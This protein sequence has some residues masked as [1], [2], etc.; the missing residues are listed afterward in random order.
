MSAQ[1][2]EKDIVPMD[3]GDLNWGSIK[4][5]LTA[6]MTHPPTDDEV[7]MFLAICQQSGLNPFTQEVYGIKYSAKDK[8]QIITSKDAFVK[9]ARAHPQFKG[10]EAGIIVIREGKV[11][12]LVGSFMLGNDKLVGGWA[13]AHLKDMSVPFE[14]KVALDEYDKGRGTWN[15][16]QKTM[17]RKVA[18]VHV[19]RE[20]F[21]EVFSKV[22]DES[23][24]D[25]AHPNRD[26]IKD[27]QKKQE[28]GEATIVETESVT[29]E[30]PAPLNP[31]LPETEVTIPETEV[32]ETATELPQTVEKE[33]E[34]FPDDE[35]ASNGDEIAGGKILMAEGGLTLNFGKHRG[36]LLYNV[37]RNTEDKEYLKWILEQDFDDDLKKIIR[38]E[39]NMAEAESA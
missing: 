8:M 14:D 19:L 34:I 3:Q 24:M 29:K 13:R 15:T 11:E 12:E 31:V 33:E 20:A 28:V 10:L 26:L 32:I 27:I 17:I 37:A 9:R 1:N 30:P 23:E 39:L 25:Q 2:N 6:N 16:L 4:K 38:D 5:F 36:K 7:R 35:G 18:I 21:P 22:Y